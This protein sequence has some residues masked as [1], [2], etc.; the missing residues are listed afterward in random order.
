MVCRNVVSRLA[1][2]ALVLVTVVAIGC[3]SG[4]KSHNPTPTPTP[5][6]TNITGTVFQDSDGDGLKSA[7]ETGIP[8]V[9]V[10]NGVTS[11]TT[12]VAGSYTLAKEG[13]F[14]FV[15]TP[16]GYATSGA[17]YRS[18]SGTQF[19]IGLK[20]APERDTDSFTFIHMTDIHLDAANLPSFQQ[21]VAEFTKIQP[22]FIVSTGD[23]VNA[24]DGKT[25]SEAQAAEW[26]GAY[27][28][29]IAGLSMPVYNALGNHDAANLACESAAGATAGCSKS[30]Y[31]S[32]FGPTY[33]SFD[34][35]DYHCVVLDPNAVSAGGEIFQ[36][37][38]VQLA[39]LQKDLSY[40]QAGSP[41][42]VF[43]HE[44]TT[45]W[46]EQSQTSVLNLLKQYQTRIFA[47]ANGHEDLLMDTQGIPQQVTAAVSGEWGNGDNPNG[48]KPGYRIVTIAGGTLDSFYKAIGS[49]Q[50]IEVS[51]AGAAWPIVNGQVGLVAKVYSESGPVTG[52][53]YSADN[54]T[55]VAMT[56]SSGAKWITARATWD[57]TALSEDYHKI[58]VA[59]T[60]N[61][62]SFQVD[63]EV[64]VSDET[65]L[66]VKDLQDHLRVYQGH[67]VTIQGTVEMA[68][69]NTGFA[70]AGAGGALIV[71]STGTALLYAGECYS[72]PLPTIDKGGT[73]QVRVIPMRFT[74]AFMTTTEDREGTY[75]QFAMQESM[76]MIPDGQK[77][78]DNGTKVA[79]WFMRVMTADDI[80]IL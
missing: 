68:M 25:I 58:T 79:R 70:P 56:L 26:F 52:V 35:G 23:L 33:Y 36:I 12:G 28:T 71:D 46:Q 73:I 6:P 60:D 19:D 9:V 47:T 17:W 34:W 5:T 48:W 66:T 21:A 44:A 29:A 50:Q 51:P 18:V 1:L 53:T 76:G 55:A 75:D 42:L 74:W 54:A 63:E 69:F 62:A 77:E 65:I 37:S 10:S 27:K 3:S 49:T 13:T 32:N 61:V 4:K 43:S 80:T 24:G 57:T 67:Y 15:T 64:K 2:V 11:T 20:A 38:A 45:S 30:A 39:W 59:A 7:T 14:V 8:N 31:R 72:P 22:A 16:S 78:D 40:R 41:L